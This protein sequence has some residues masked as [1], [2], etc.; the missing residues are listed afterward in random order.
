MVYQEFEWARASLD[1]ARELRP[2]FQVSVASTLVGDGSCKEK[3]LDCR[4]KLS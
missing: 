3:R 4:D 2:W 1:N